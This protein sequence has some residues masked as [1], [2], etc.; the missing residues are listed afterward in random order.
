MVKFF[1]CT[2]M[3]LVSF[4]TLNSTETTPGNIN[5]IENICIVVEN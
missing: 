3:K 1:E 5:S 4:S 2:T